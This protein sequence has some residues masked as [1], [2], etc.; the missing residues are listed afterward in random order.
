MGELDPG[1]RRHPLVRRHH[2]HP[3]DQGWLYLASV[4][5]IASRRV[6]G[7]AT[8]DHL[9]IELVAD[10]LRAAC[11]S[12]RPDGPV[13]FHSDRGCQGGF[14]RWSQHLDR[15]GVAWDGQ[16]VGSRR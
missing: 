5:H 8:A 1:G 16:Q 9:R 7:W 10:A 12:R 2:V 6:V 11:P 14:N 3:T 13:V 4:I 15:D